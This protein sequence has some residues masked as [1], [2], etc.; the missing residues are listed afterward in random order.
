MTDVDIT[1]LFGLF[2]ENMLK[3]GADS[4]EYGR[5]RTGNQKLLSYK[6]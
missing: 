3:V 6:K 2:S 4:S 1:G 5:G